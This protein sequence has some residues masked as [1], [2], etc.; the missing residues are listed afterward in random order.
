MV[1]DY[2]TSTGP[3]LIRHLTNICTHRGHFWSIFSLLPFLVSVYQWQR[4]FPECMDTWRGSCV[5]AC[6]QR[7]GAVAVTNLSSSSVSLQLF[8]GKRSV[9]SRKGETDK[10]LCVFVCINNGGETICL[11]YYSL[12]CQ[13]CC[14][15]YGMVELFRSV[16]TFI[17]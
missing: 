16:R 12:G 11:V 5:Y 15:R 7:E 3:P 14:R 9:C 13:A 1:P 6:V 10:K 17:L 4:A 2:T 8:G